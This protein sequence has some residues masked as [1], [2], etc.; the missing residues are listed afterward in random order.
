MLNKYIKTDLAYLKVPVIDEN[1]YVDIRGNL[2][3]PS[4][5]GF[6]LLEVDSIMTVHIA[7]TPYRVSV[8]NIIQVTWK[9]V[10]PED[11]LYYL[12]HRSV[13]LSDANRANRHPI[14]LLWGFE[15]SKV[16]GMFRIPGFSRYLLTEDG[17]VY[18]RKLGRTVEVGYIEGRHATIYAVPD[19]VVSRGNTITIHRLIALAKIE[20]DLKVNNLEVNHINGNKWDFRED[21][22]EWVTRAGNVKHAQDT[23]L[24]NDANEITVKDLN[25]GELTVYTSQAQCAEAINIDC[26]NLSTAL[27]RGGGIYTYAKRYEVMVTRFGKPRPKFLSTAKKTL[28]KDLSTSK[29]YN[30]DSLSEAAKFLGMKPSTLKKRYLRGTTVFGNMHLKAYNPLLGEETPQ[31]DS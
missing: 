15:I 24:K 17:M 11:F 2:F 26:R 1:I 9:P 7:G 29:I 4:I 22:L 20:Y 27:R 28:I 5:T 10:V 23:R 3:A 6:D 18:S 21:N 14:N 16:D 30:F 25:T 19:Y 8:L 12:V 31:F 13:L